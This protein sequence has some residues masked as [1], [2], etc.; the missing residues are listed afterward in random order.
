MKKIGIIF[1]AYIGILEIVLFLATVTLM[2]IEDLWG[3][4]I[5]Q[6]T[7]IAATMAIIAAIV[8]SAGAVF[9]FHHEWNEFENTTWDERMGRSTKVGLILGL[10]LAP[11]TIPLIAFF[12]EEKKV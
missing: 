6:T 8:H 10:L 11:M 12:E 5:P 2:T 3:L 1:L 4:K 9:F 7:S